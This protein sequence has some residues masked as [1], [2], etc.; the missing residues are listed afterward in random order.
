M[1]LIH[2]YGISIENLGVGVASPRPGR[3]PPEAPMQASAEALAS[4]SFGERVLGA[5]KLDPRTYEEVE[6][7]PAA[8]GQAAGVVAMG[9]VAAGVGDP[10]GA[11]G[12]FA[13]VGL[14]G[15]LVGWLMIAAL[16]WIVGVWC[17]KRS[18]TYPELLRAS[19]FASAPEI[20]LPLG[21]LPVAGPIAASVTCLWALAAYVVAVR[22]ALGVGTARAAWVCGL[23]FGLALF[24]T[25]VLS[26]LAGG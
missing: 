10:Q 6:R 12:A 19:G 3:P 9:A 14:A 8:L 23:A 11:S 5:L 20:A 15:A 26:R 18:S 16:I 7:D 22:Q 1:G 25:A 2:E 21:L 17:M 13:L 4:H 24:L